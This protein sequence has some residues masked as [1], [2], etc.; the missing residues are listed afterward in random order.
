MKFGDAGLGFA[1]PSFRQAGRAVCSNSARVT[2]AAAILPVEHFGPALP[3]AQA[4][5]PPF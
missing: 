2:G 5:P 3:P 1:C 4:E